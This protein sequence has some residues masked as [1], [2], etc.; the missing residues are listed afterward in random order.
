MMNHRTTGR[1]FRH[2][3][4][5]NLFITFCSIALAT[6]GFI[7]HYYHL[8]VYIKELNEIG[9]RKLLYD[10]CKR[11]FQFNFCSKTS[12]LRFCLF[13]SFSKVIS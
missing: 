10:L 8:L 6:V 4:L 7:T 2:L 5:K 11:S 1:K 13:L 3:G 9:L 12:I